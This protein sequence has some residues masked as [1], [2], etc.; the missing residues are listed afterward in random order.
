MIAFIITPRDYDDDDDDDDHNDIV[1][2]DDDDTACLSV[3][4]SFGA[5]LMRQ[6]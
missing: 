1:D 6:V 4:S 5:G 3:A 2:D